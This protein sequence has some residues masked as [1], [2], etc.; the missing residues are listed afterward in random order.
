MRAL[1]KSITVFIATI[2][3]GLASIIASGCGPDIHSLVMKD[4]IEKLNKKN[5]TGVAVNSSGEFTIVIVAPQRVAC[6]DR[7]G[8]GYQETCPFDEP[9]AQG[10]PQPVQANP[11]E[12]VM[13]LGLKM[14]ID[15][16]P[17][18]VAKALQQP[19]VQAFP[20]AKIVYNSPPAVDSIVVEPRVEA[21]WPRFGRIVGIAELTVTMPNGDTFTINTISEERNSLAHLGWAIP[22]VIVTVP[23]GLAIVV[24][25]GDG[26]KDGYYEAT[27]AEALVLAGK[28]L[29][30]ELAKRTSEPSP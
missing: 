21:R 19:I 22:L 29:A 16:F 7:T 23:I 20:K 25:T 9:D 8:K 28:K 12:N 17:S 30:E 14:A 18:Q 1:V 5:A 27:M 6:E 24:G 11:E 4:S 3:L 10:N 13:P 2:S 26:I 15:D